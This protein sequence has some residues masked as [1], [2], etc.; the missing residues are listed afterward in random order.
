MAVTLSVDVAGRF[1]AFCEVV[2]EITDGCAAVTPADSYAT[3]RSESVGVP[4]MVPH[5]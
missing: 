4:L 5:A 2:R 3:T 1:R